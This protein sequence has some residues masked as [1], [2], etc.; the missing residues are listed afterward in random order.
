MVASHAQ[1][2]PCTHKSSL[3][4]DD[5]LAKQRLPSKICKRYE[6]KVPCWP[7]TG[8]GGRQACRGTNESRMDCAPPDSG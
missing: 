1:I 5:R 4:A 2:L 6:A 7:G 3:T 8:R